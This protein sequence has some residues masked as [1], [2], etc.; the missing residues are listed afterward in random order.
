MKSFYCEEYLRSREHSHTAQVNSLHGWCQ[1]AD[2]KQRLFPVGLW[3]QHGT[4]PFGLSN[5]SDVIS[6]IR[7]DF[8]AP[9]IRLYAGFS[10]YGAGFTATSA[11][12]QSCDLLRPA[13]LDDGA[14]I[15]NAHKL[16]RGGI[17][18]AD[19]LDGIGLFQQ[20]GVDDGDSFHG[21]SGCQ[22]QVRTDRFLP[23][24]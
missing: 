24:Q 16:E 17:Q 10:M 4:T 20:R 12:A 2:N 7:V 22:P 5:W 6:D 1:R 3:F 23:V 21:A 14:Q 18:G 15:A 9:D 8:A 11:L 19:S 13:G